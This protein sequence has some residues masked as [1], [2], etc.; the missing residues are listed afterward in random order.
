MEQLDLFTQSGPLARSHD[1]LSSHKAN[2]AISKDGTLARMICDGV[3]VNH[4]LSPHVGVTDDVLLGY[5]ETRTAKRQ[6]RNVIAR[7]RGLLE[8]NG[9]FLRVPGDRVSVIP[10]DKLLDFYKEKK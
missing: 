10:T 2:L 9:Y 8:R 1:P 3:I 7:A 6:Q 5:I 4:S